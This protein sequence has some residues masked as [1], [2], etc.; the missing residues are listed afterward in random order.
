M[1][2]VINN[3]IEAIEGAFTT[4]LAHRIMTNDWD[5]DTGKISEDEALIG[6]LI[7]AVTASEGFLGRMA[8]RA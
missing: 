5:W 8:A 3:V 6:M 4:G 7:G 2:V 1:R